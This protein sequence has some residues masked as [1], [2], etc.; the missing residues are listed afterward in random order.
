MAFPRRQP[1]IQSRPC[2]RHG[3]QLRPK[4]SHGTIQNV[5]HKKSEKCQCPAG[6]FLD[7][8]G[9]KRCVNT[10]EELERVIFYASEGQDRKGRDK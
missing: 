9:S 4:I 1:T 10:E 3:I 8:G 2:G 7:R 5:V 6:E